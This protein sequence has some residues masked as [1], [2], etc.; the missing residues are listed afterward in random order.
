MLL[1]GDT[2]HFSSSYLCKAALEPL[3]PTAELLL[4]KKAAEGN[5]TARETLIRANIRFAVAYA[6]KF[7]GHGLSCEDLEAEAVVGLI[8]AIDHFDCTHGARIITYASWWIR[9]E[10]LAALNKC[11]ASQR[12]SDR[13]FRMLIQVQKTLQQLQDIENDAE[14]LQKA[15][16]IVGISTEQLSELLEANTAAIS[17][18]AESGDE[19]NQTALQ[20]HIADSASPT[21][22]ETALGNCLKEDLEAALCTLGETERNVLMLHYGLTVN[23]KAL[24][25]AEIAQKYGLTKQWAFFKTQ[26]AEKHLAKKLCAMPA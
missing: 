17:L 5:K 14:R 26:A 25:Y 20:D 9:N 1:K 13:N 19:K 16:E 4:A 18:Q 21:V 6:K 3:N 12:L 10:V 11:G 15:A 7:Q 23:K 8:K 24:S 22:E 2:L